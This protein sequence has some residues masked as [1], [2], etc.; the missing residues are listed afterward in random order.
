MDYLGKKNILTQRYRRKSFDLI[1]KVVSKIEFKD[2]KAIFV[3]ISGGPAC[4]IT[5]ISKFFHKRITKSEIIKELSFFKID[6]QNRN[7]S[8]ENEYL[9][10]DYDNYSKKRRLYLIDICS[11]DSFDYDKFF[12]I[13]NTLKK[14]EKIRI[15]FFDEEKCEYVPEKD[16]IVDPIKTPLIIV[17]GYYIFKDKRVRDMLNL[18]IYKD[19]EDD[20]RLS[21][22][23]LREE[24]YLNKDKNAYKI[25]FYIYAKYFKISFKENIYPFKSGA[26]IQLPD[27]KIQNENNE[28]EEDETLEFLIRNLAY[29]TKRKN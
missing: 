20:V 5:K 21:R 29:F 14:G 2:Q 26:N 8:K 17:E 15:P 11:P 22:L 18:K 9:V 6:N 3:G 13:L 7:I 12:E 1:E 19:V 25:F 28:I 16:K 4:G 10:K 24:K 23:I 27:Y